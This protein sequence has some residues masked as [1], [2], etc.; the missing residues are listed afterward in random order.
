M[1]KVTTG[2]VLPSACQYQKYIVE[3]GKLHQAVN[4]VL[5]QPATGLH[6]RSGVRI[7]QR[8]GVPISM[9]INQVHKFRF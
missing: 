8:V 9:E 4:G 2:L 7:A 6:S 5:R 1:G 3:D